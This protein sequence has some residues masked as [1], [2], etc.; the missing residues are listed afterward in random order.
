MQFKS[1]ADATCTFLLI[2][3]IRNS[4]VDCNIGE[5]LAILTNKKQFF[6]VCRRKESGNEMFIRLTCIQKVDISAI[7]HKSKRTKVLTFF[8]L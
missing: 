4:R 5:R 6:Q 8:N 3:A 1:F 7:C 2:E